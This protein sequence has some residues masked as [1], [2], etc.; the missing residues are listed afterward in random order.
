[1][2][3][4]RIF[5]GTLFR[6]AN[7]FCTVIAL[8]TGQRVFLSSLLTLPYSYIHHKY[9]IKNR[10]MVSTSPLSAPGHIS[11]GWAA[12]IHTP[13]VPVP[14]CSPC[15][16]TQSFNPWCQAEASSLLMLAGSWPCPDRESQHC[17]L[18]QGQGQAVAQERAAPHLVGEALTGL[19][20]LHTMAGQQSC[21]QGRHWTAMVWRLAFKMNLHRLQVIIKC[22][23]IKIKVQELL[24]LYRR[25]WQTAGGSQWPKQQKPKLANS[26]LSEEPFLAV[27]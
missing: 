11:Q 17:R 15:C 22:Q 26:N 2:I 12:W 5:L 13:V 14:L 21:S 27:N 19:C 9:L 4:P 25:I 7:L 24:S 10:K 8:N 23:G 3:C 6:L 18:G 1:M 16:D 20:H